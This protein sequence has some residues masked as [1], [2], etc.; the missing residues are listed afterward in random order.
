[1]LGEQR[2]DEAEARAWISSRPEAV[3][4]AALLRPL[5]QDLLFPTLAQIAGPSETAYL[6]QSAVLYAALGV[7]QPVVYPRVSAT[8]LD[9]KA[10]RLIE[11][12][13]LELDQIWR[14][15]AAELLARQALPPGVEA[16][17][18]GMRARFDNDFNQLAGELTT[19]DP[20]LVDAAQ[21]AVQKIRHQLEQLEGR[22]AR[23]FAR[24]SQE[25]SGQAQHLDG[26]L[27]P[28]RQLQER[29]LAGAGFIAPNPGLVARLHDSLAVEV[30]DHQIVDL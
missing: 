1:M 27:F 2:L 3:S 12:N 8:L 9:A 15:P 16:R 11:K 23:S 28:N 20:T 5:A 25:L 10:R 18:T 22:V 29:V 13:G 30:P 4:P 17:V 24:R 21:G 26:S 19:L 14:E 6:A 7:R